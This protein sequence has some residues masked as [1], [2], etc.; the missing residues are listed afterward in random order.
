[1]S[2][3]AS[4]RRSLIASRRVRDEAVTAY[5][6]LSPYLLVTLVF[7]IGVILFA[8][9]VSFTEF[10]L[11]TWPPTWV[12]LEN[13][14]NALT[15]TKFIRS[16]V[17][18]L[19]YV[20]LVVPLQTGLALILAVLVNSKVRGS[21]YYRSAFYAP[22][23]TS[24]VVI[25]MIFWWLYLKTGYLNFGITKALALI[26]VQW[27]ALEWLGDP[28]G[29]L[30]ILLGPLGVEISS[31]LWYLRGPS[32]TW[33]AIMFQNIFTTAPTF[34]IMFLAAL[35]DVPP[36]LYEAS[37]IDGANN[38][39][40][41]FRITVPMLRPVILLIVVLGT[42]GTWQVFDQVKI[43]TSG[44]PLNT[45]LT[46]VYLI[47]AEALGISGPPRMGFAGAM[48]FILAVIIFTFTFVQRRYIERGTELY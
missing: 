38:R 46:P 15:D 17:N 7:T 48:A 32:I 16:L 22:S 10:D 9:Y 34:M 33:M 35:Q 8:V 39:Q 23:V 24:S 45:T 20:V 29:L 26:G 14:K 42:I 18:A 3:A 1:M 37:S 41:F 25:S 40:Q 47:Y 36:S 4:P 5:L 2:D 44:G 11:F 12:G 30:Q 31:D 43:L 28:R 19:W 21:N 27:E 6:F 13:Y